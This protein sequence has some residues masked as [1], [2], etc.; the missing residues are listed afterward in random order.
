MQLKS[1]AL[2]GLGRLWRRI[3][4][5][6][7]RRRPFSLRLGQ[8]LDG[9]AA[10]LCIE[11]DGGVVLPEKR[12]RRHV[13]VVGNDRQ[14]KNLAT[15]LLCNEIVRQDNRAQLFVF[16]TEGDPELAGHVK[17]R[18]SSHRRRHLSFPNQPFDL[19]AGQDWH[20]IW[21]RLT[22]IIPQPSADYRSERIADWEATVLRAACCGGEGPPRSAEELLQRLSD[23]KLASEM[24]GLRPEL[25]D[26]V[27]KRCQAVFSCFGT[28]LDGRWSFR[29]VDSVFFRLDALSNAE[30][31]VM[32][33]LN[34]QLLRYITH[35]K[36]PAR[37]TFVVMRVA[38]SP[39][40]ELARLLEVA[41]ARGVIVMLQFL[42]S[43]EV[44]SSSQIRQLGATAGT[45]VLQGPGAWHDLEQIAGPGEP[46][47]VFAGGHFESVP[48]SA[49]QGPRITR[50]ELLH[51]PPGRGAV[52][53]P[54]GVTIV[55]I[56]PRQD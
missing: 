36:D 29:D 12:L 26:N 23:L 44:G 1:K 45:V 4:W 16:D 38:G 34:A 24:I 13:V 10:G 21:K 41:R 33:M 11:A 28:T 55:T 30:G 50:E 19:W 27:Y 22:E 42:T 25:A 53:G 9:T 8:Y 49:W 3:S 46:S 5:R 56:S 32:R 39:D 43:A 20:P 15:L 2:Q 31:A 18:M 14:G 6:P 37:R 40:V 17:D 51:L 47:D 54:D 35:E 52:L 7:R 48:T